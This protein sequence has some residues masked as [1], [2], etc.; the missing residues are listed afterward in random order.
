VNDD[1]SKKPGQDV[2]DARKKPPDHEDL[3]VDGRHIEAG[4]DLLSSGTAKS[5]DVVTIIPKKDDQQRLDLYTMDT[6][7]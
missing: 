7:G 2:K 1:A 3:E 4:I 5:L 6:N